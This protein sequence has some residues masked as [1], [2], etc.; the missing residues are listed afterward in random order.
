MD[1][2]LQLYMDFFPSSPFIQPSAARN[3]LTFGEA[4]TSELQEEASGGVSLMSVWLMT[5]TGERR[6][7]EREEP[8]PPLGPMIEEYNHGKEFPTLKSLPGLRF[9]RRADPRESSES[10]ALN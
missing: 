4:A 9:R 7:K 3:S 1:S 2:E 6:S 8:R 10:A 5:L